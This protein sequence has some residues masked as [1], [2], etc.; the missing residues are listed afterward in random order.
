MTAAVDDGAQAR[1]TAEAVQYLTGVRDLVAGAVEVG[2][3]LVTFSAVN[4]EL[5]RSAVHTSSRSS[6]VAGCGIE[7]TSALTGARGGDKARHRG[8]P[9]D[10]SLVDTNRR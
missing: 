4:T 8:D 2:G 6:A 9:G 1:G 10:T 5:V 3:Q 7:V